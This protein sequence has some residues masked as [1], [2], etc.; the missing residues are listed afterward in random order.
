VAWL[1]GLVVVVAVAHLFRVAVVGVTTEDE[2]H[3]VA[4]VVVCES[5][6]DVL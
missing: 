1:K 5:H 4:V 3:A 2:T 6:N